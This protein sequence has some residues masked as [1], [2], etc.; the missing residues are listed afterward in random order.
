MLKGYLLHKKGERYNAFRG[1]AILSLNE[2]AK[3]RIGHELSN[4]IS[5]LKEDSRSQIDAIR[6]LEEMVPKG[7]DGCVKN[8]YGYIDS[9]D[10]NTE[11]PFHK[12][13]QPPVIPAQHFTK[14]VGIK[15]KK[16]IEWLLKCFADL[17]RNNITREEFFSPL[18]EFIDS[19]FYKNLERMA[20]GI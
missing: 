19:D 8:Q 1:H 5:I 2:E 17:K 18:V 10:E 13:E 14:E 4:I 7:K 11:Y 20:R 6:H 16:A 15:Y 12:R 3:R 9:I